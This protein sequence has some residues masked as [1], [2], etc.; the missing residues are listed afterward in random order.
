V[1]VTGNTIR[2]TDTQGIFIQTRRP[3]SPASAG[4]TADLTLR[5]NSVANIDDNSLFPFI[6][7]YGTEIWSRNNSNLCL[8][9]AGNTS[10]GIGG[11]EHFR[12]RQRDTS[13][14]RLERLTGS[15][16]DDANVASFVAAQNAAGSTAAATHATAFTAVADG[17]CRNP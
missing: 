9:I 1:S 10:T 7:Q 17:T 15:G 13:T 5:N 3:I 11:F 12:V 16:S 14:F 4:P 6:S 8:D 2:H